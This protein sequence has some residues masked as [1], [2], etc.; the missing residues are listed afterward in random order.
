[1]VLASAVAVV[2]AVAAVGRHQLTEA[3]RHL[4]T[5]VVVEV[6]QP[7]LTLTARL[8]T[9]HSLVASEPSGMHSAAEA[10]TV[11]A[12]TDCTAL[13]TKA[14]V[15][16][17]VVVVVLTEV[18]LLHHRR[19]TMGLV[20]MVTM[21]E[22]VVWKILATIKLQAPSTTAATATR[23]SVRAEEMAN[24]R[25]RSHIHHPTTNVPP[26]STHGHTHRLVIHHRTAVCLALL[27]EGHRD[28]LDRHEVGEEVVCTTQHRARATG[29]ALTTATTTATM[30]TTTTTATTTTLTMLMLMV[31]LTSTATTLMAS[32]GVRGL[33]RLRFDNTTMRTWQVQVVQPMKRRLQE[34]TLLCRCV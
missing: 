2:A 8:T 22:V 17:V 21:A 30:L 34:K 23:A 5:V 6:H 19:T 32:L 33:V 29:L 18:G 26:Q 9:T 27:A 15:A 24:P 12:L 28:S 10:E 7:M 14:A 11:Q 31:T 16:A 20:T 13:E 4:H 1:L 25:A 3:G